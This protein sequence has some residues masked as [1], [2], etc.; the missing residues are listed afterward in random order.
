MKT[1]E[2]KK[3][4][5]EQVI[6]LLA[7]HV[8]LTWNSENRIHINLNVSSGDQMELHISTVVTIKF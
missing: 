6:S 7:F 2:C 3:S 4:I 5:S 1:R 8:N